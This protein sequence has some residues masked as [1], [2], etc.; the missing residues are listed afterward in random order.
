MA[1]TRLSPHFTLDELTTTSVRGVDNTP[2]ARQLENLRRLCVETLEPIRQRFGPWWVTSGYRS[3]AVNRIIGGSPTSAHMCIGD[4][5]AADGVPL[6]R[7]V[8]WSSVIHFLIEGDIPFDQVIYEY[9]RWLHIGIDA[10]DRCRRQALM[11]FEPG[12]YLPWNP[13]DPRITR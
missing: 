6:A 11:V 9:G 7:N 10:P 3:P 12:T 2:D 8:R 4:R 5:A 13:T 1:I